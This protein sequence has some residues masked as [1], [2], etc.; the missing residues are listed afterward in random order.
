MIV[1]M[2]KPAPQRRSPAWLSPRGRMFHTLA[3]TVL[4][5]A[6]TA[7][8]ADAPVSSFNLKQLIDLGQRENRDLQAARYAVN[9]SQARL[10]QAGLRPNPRLDLSTRSDFAFN[11]EGEYDRAIAV[12]QEFPIAGR[13]LRQKDVARV[14]VALAQAEVAEAERRLAE[15]IAAK[16]YRLLVTQQQI[17]SLDMLIAAEEALAKTARA[18]Y[19][20]AE[21]SE[22]DVNTVQLDLQRLNLEREQLQ[23]EL[24]TISVSLNTLL[25]RPATAPFTVIEPLPYQDSLPSL[26]N[27]QTAALQRRPDL[28]SALLGVDRAAAEKALARALRWQDW[29]VALE[30][31]QGKQVILGAPSQGT[32]RTIG[33]SVSIPLPLFNKSQGL[34]AEADA[35]RD[36]ATAR[37]EAVRLTILSE[38]TGAHAEATRLQVLLAQFDLSMRPVSE[39]N[40]RLARQGYGQGLIPIFDVVQAQRQQAELNQTYLSTLDQFLQALVRLHTAAGDYTPNSLDA[41]SQP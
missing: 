24:Q 17:G 10:L 37:V 5:L 14:D 25:G 2:F 1:S 36:Q 20:A 3:A 11:N 39:R 28:Q 38:V 21:V 4:L 34:L 41:N 27:L 22:L 6:N 32:D 7:A 23:S 15:Q 35:N 40:V 12:S 8:L 9:V 33:V 29:S 31:S 30:L 19:R 18:R 26:E 16:V 13:L